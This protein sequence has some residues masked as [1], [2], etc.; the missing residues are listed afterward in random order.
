MGEKSEEFGKSRQNKRP[1]R[2]DRQNK[3]LLCLSN[4]CSVAFSKCCY[5]MSPCDIKRNIASALPTTNTEILCFRL[6]HYHG[7]Q[8]RSAIRGTSSGLCRGPRIEGESIYLFVR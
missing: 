4:R 2:S 5:R 8:A 7:A 3:R 1:L 6:I